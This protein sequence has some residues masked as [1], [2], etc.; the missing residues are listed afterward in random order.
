MCRMGVLLIVR[1]QHIRAESEGGQPER[2]LVFKIR[3]WWEIK[4]KGQWARIADATA[5][6]S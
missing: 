4:G 3:N 1:I 2:S 6:T 5:P